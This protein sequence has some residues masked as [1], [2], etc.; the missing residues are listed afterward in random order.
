VDATFDSFDQLAET[1]SEEFNS[2]L[3]GAYEE[4]RPVLQNGSLDQATAKKVFEVIRKRTLELQDLSARA[5]SDLFGPILDKHP[6]IK[7]KLGDGYDQLKKLASQSGPEAQ[8]IAKDTATQLTDVFKSGLNDK[9]ISKAKQIIQDSAERLQKATGDVGD[10]AKQAWNKS[11]EQAQPYLDKIPEIKELLESKASVLMVGGSAKQI[12]DQVKE[13]GGQKR[14]DKEKLKDLKELIQSKVEDAGN[15]SGDIWDKV[16]E[17]SKNISGDKVSD[18]ISDWVRL[19]DMG[20]VGRDEAQNG[21][22]CSG[23]PAR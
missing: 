9:S 11:M 4:L 5:S 1:H 17:F 21:R 6:E 12:W 3:R 2:I 7:E 19:H 20:L 18:L 13:I 22:F 16:V 8:R 10:G 14:V 23:R 15:S